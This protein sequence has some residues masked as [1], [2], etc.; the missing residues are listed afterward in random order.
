MTV[1]AIPYWISNDGQRT[2]IHRMTISKVIANLQLFNVIVT[3][4]LFVLLRSC[5]LLFSDAVV[6]LDGHLFY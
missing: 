5:C 1:G 6:F 4:C 3:N 2:T